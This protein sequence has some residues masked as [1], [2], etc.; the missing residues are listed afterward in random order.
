MDS[1]LRSLL[2][3]QGF[4]HHQYLANNNNLFHKYSGLIFIRIRQP[5]I[6]DEIFTKWRIFFDFI[7]AFISS[8]ISSKGLVSCKHI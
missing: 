4:H 1:C 5:R 6:K 2:Y 7:R 8:K 3:R